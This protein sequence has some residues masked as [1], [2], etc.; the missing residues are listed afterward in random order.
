[1]MNIILPS[2]TLERVATRD[3]NIKLLTLE[4]DLDTLAE[5][6]AAAE[7]FGARSKST[8]MNQYVVQKIREAKEMVSKE[9]FSEKFSKHLKKIKERS[10]RKSRERINSQAASSGVETK[11]IKL[12]EIFISA[13]DD[14]DKMKIQGES[15]KKLN[16]KIKKT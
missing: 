6:S 12:D 3:P 2:N 4:V 1:M 14:E 13:P 10:K 8:F 9:E 7:I 15:E 16:N 5:F 11:T